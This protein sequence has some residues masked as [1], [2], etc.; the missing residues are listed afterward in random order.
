MAE[1]RISI[2]GIVGKG[3]NRF[4]KNKSRYRV[5]K[6]GRGSKKSTTTALNY[7]KR[8]MEY[9][10]ANLLV[11]RQTFKT[12]K[13]ST[14]A[15]L[16]W[17]CNKLGV[18]HLWNFTVSPLEAV[19]IPTGQKIL[20][21][22]F[23]DPLKI[24]SITVDK[25][26]L[27]W[28][29]IE[30]A[31]E[32]R[33]EEDFNKLDLSIRGTLPP[34]YF[35]QFTISFNPWS[36]KHWLKKRFFD[37]FDEDVFALTTTYK[38]NEYLDK[39]DLKVFEKMKEQHPKRYAVEGEGNWGVAE[40]TVYQYMVLDFDKNDILSRKGHEIRSVF[41][42]DFGYTN[43]PSAFVAV[44]ID[45]TEKEMYI[46][47]ENYQRA[48]KNPDL[49]AMI[50]YKGYAKE[51]IIADCAEPKSIDE[52]KDHGIYRIEAVDKGNDSILYGIQKVQQYKI[53]VHPNCYWTQV[54]LDNYIW[55]TKDNVRLNK[56][57]DDWNH[58]MDALRYAVMAKDKKG[59][60]GAVVV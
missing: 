14:F 6:G 53:Y 20:F 58:I 42:L 15:Q 1:Q 32:I 56:P 29:W 46:F 51:R 25:G 8:M 52:I 31:Y 18:S 36:E 23:D 24:T 41:G 13:D 45:E 11:V 28:V 2:R 3:Y 57:I 40:G 38:C 10:E 22:G 49:A 50:K 55:D 54:E 4:W 33:N 19:Y 59:F 27:C 35:K 39:A 9:P 21:R 5:V 16:K 47:D 43:D 30:E 60:I 26:Y 17:A 37:S 44:V 7:I 12:H 48:M 34:G